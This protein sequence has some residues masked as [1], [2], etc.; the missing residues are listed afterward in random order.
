MP[1]N[2]AEKYIAY[3]KRYIPDYEYDTKDFAVVDIHGYEKLEY[4]KM[5][6]AEPE[7]EVIYGMDETEVAESKIVPIEK[8][9]DLYRVCKHLSMKIK[10][11]E[12]EIENL[13]IDV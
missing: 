9:L 11:L 5:K 8:E 1:S 4:W 3:I 13:K 7:K 6:L 2:L 10:K 12:I